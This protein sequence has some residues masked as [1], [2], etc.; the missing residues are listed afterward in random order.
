M[1]AEA[2]LQDHLHSRK[3]SLALLAQEPEKVT[4]S[5]AGYLWKRAQY[6]R[7]WLKRWLV[8][9]KGVFRQ[10]KSPGEVCPMCVS[11]RPEGSESRSSAPGPV[12]C[13]V[14][15]HRPCWSG[16]CGHDGHLPHTLLGF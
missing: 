10:G 9:R 14:S 5:H 11:G 8:C 12:S 16:S 1:G 4:L 3:V 15:Q 6:K 2:G 13:R 7:T